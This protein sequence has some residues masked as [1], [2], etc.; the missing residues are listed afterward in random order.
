MKLLVAFD[1][2]DHSVLALDEA[3]DVAV[4]DGADVT[5]LSVLPPSARG[6]KSGGHMGLPPH[7][8][9]SARTRRRCLGDHGVQEPETKVAGHPGAGS[10]RKRRRRL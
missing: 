4:V 6:S 5:V 7:G 3:V 9:G 1:R 10:C 2:E 8:C